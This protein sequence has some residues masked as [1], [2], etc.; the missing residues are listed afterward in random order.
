MISKSPN[1]GLT[2]RQAAD[3]AR[4]LGNGKE[5][6]VATHT[7]PDG[8]AVASLLA[9][10]EIVRMLGGRAVE[11]LDG[12]I[13]ERFQFLPGGARIQP[14]ERLENRNYDAALILDSGNVSRIGRAAEK[15]PA[16]KPIVNVDHHPDNTFFGDLNLVF[17]EAAST[18]SLL[19]EISQAL[20]LRLTP[21]LAL[22]LYT[23]LLTDTGGFRFSNTTERAFQ[24][25]ARLVASGVDPAAVADELFCRNTIE[26]VKLLGEALLSLRVSD[27]GKVASMS[28]DAN[29]LHQEIEE[30]ADL[31]LTVK[32]VQAAAFFRQDGGQTRVSLRSR[33]DYDVGKIARRYGGGGHQKAAG[34]SYTGSLQEIRARVIQALCEEVGE[35]TPSD[36]GS[37]RIPRRS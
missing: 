23:G 10:A 16:G 12:Q 32:G 31:A 14:P 6:L 24:I 21:S 2:A 26:G 7:S 18:T 35:D 37:E 4:I 9:G 17:P 20:Q 3:F 22:W 25:A 33:G 34:F 28:V 8:D 36:S 29:P 27:G 30:I 13:P 5:I 11:V 15:I 1:S 19:Y